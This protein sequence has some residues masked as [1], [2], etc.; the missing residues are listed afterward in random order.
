MSLRLTHF[1]NVLASLRTQ[2]K[3]SAQS[4]KQKKMGRNFAY[5]HGEC[6]S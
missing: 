2:D 3:Y 4:N 6:V 5:D 1:F